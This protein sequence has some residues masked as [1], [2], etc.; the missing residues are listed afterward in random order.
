MWAWARMGSHLDSPWLAVTNTPAST[1]E[2]VVGSGDTNFGLKYHVR[3]EESSRVPALALVAYL[4]LPT[5]D[6]ERGLGSG[7]TDVWVYTVAEK[8]LPHA[9]SVIG[10]LGPLFAA[11]P[12]LAFS[13]FKR[14][15][16]MS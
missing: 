10:N 16:V 6:A 1:P 3:D 4:E 14:C 15:A 11:I 7:L 12:Q 8:H 2:R 9:V 5:G 13:A